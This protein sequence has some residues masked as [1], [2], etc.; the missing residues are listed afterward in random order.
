MTHQE[1]IAYLQQLLLAR[2]KQAF[3]ERLDDMIFPQ[4]KITKPK[5][6]YR[7]V[8]YREDHLLDQN[9]KAN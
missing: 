2:Y 1:E 3:I 6:P 7:P 4:Q 5:F 8:L 9:S